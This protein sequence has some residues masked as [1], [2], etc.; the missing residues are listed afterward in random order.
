MTADV[1][2][3]TYK[4]DFD[5]LGYCLKAIRK[6]LQGF[7]NIVI[8][9]PFKDAAGLVSQEFFMKLHSKDCVHF[10]DEWEGMGHE[11][12]NYIKSTAHQLTDADYI[13]HLD[14]DTLVTESVKVE[15][16]FQDGK[17][18]WS[19]AFYSEQPHV[20]WRGVTENLLGFECPREFMQSFPFLIKRKTYE[21]LE[22][23]VKTR[24]GYGLERWIKEAPKI[25]NAFRNYSEF[26]ALGSIAYRYQQDEYVWLKKD[27]KDLEWKDG[28][29][30]NTQWPFSAI[31][32]LWSH[33]GVNHP[34]YK[35]LL[36]SI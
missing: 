10:L 4:K 23:H 16:F 30:S 31:K 8:A 2:I 1:F 20:P 25:G 18:I 12:Q 22:E 19:Y 3:V 33:H 32:Q 13:L 11:W 26:N 27:A 15:D 14:C 5:W 28:I 24:C 36:E 35:T 9:C 17:P 6:N 34:E 21:I 29:C 7:R